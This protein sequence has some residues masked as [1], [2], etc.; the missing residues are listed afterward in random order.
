MRCSVATIDENILATLQIGSTRDTPDGV[1][2]SHIL[3]L[4]KK[5]PRSGPALKKRIERSDAHTTKLSCHRSLHH[6]CSRSLR[7]GPKQG[8]G[9]PHHPQGGD[10]SAYAD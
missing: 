1:I 10:R 4:I 7:A 6:G 8:P 3:N 9:C 2:A 5:R